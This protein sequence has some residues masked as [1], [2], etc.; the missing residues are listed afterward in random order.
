MASRKCSNDPDSFCYI[1]GRFTFAKNRIE[2]DDNV[3]GFYRNYFNIPISNQDKSWAPH[4]ACKSCV[5]SLRRWNNAKSNV[6]PMP[7]KTPMIWREAVSHD[8]CYFCSTKTFGFNAKNSHNI[9]YPNVASVTKP[10]PYKSDDSPP[11]PPL[12]KQKVEDDTGCDDTEDHESE[13]TAS[14]YDEYS[15]STP[16]LF[17]QAALN[18]LVRDLGLPKDKSELL[19]S[20]LK[21]RNLLAPGTTFCWYRDREKSLV[22][23]FSEGGNCVFCNDV[24][25]FMQKL[26]LL[27]D[28][29]HWRLF[30]D[31]SK[32]S[33]KAVL[34]HNS[35]KYASI[36]IA[37]SV[38]LNE[39]YE[40]VQTIL[41][42]IEYEQHKW[43]VCEDLKVICMLLGQQSGYTK[44]PCFICLWDSRDRA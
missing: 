39:S 33:L 14:I 43:Q 25:G 21:E 2:I 35:N 29:A 11:T 16:I 3:K 19:G 27:Y 42:A 4:M 44:Y 6:T 28:T 37:H 17:D 24:S 41:E 8:E 22:G 10:T 20:R 23:F 5:E 26:G 15:D 38:Y 30:I 13:N 18:D 34:L 36:P 32:R 31:S 7:F 40:N 1:C 12:L 9:K